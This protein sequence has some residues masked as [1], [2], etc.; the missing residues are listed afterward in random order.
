MSQRRR[1]RNSLR[2]MFSWLAIVTV[3]VQPVVAW[4]PTCHCAASPVNN[5]AESQS[6][7][8]SVK[9]GS[10]C[11]IDRDAARSLNDCCTASRNTTS[12]C[13][14]DSSALF[15]QCGNCQCADRQEP[16]PVPPAVPPTESQKT[17]TQ[18]FLTLAFVDSI[19]T[20]S[21]RYPKSIQ[22]FPAKPVSHSAQQSCV[23]LSRFTC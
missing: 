13:R 2:P 8:D 11:G 14:C 10:C 5:A 7:C 15:C 19:H 21:D 16:P 9:L 6:S 4:M 17:P 23:L 22:F 12:A 3:F 18:T 1:M 20:R